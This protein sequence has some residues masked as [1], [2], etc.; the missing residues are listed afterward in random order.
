MFVEFKNSVKVSSLFPMK[1]RRPHSS[2]KHVVALGGA[3]SRRDLHYE[4]GL[5]KEELRGA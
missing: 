4:H 2:T 1:S 5:V 3:L